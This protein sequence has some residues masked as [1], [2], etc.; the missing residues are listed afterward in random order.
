MKTRPSIIALALMI[1][2]LGLGAGPAFLENNLWDKGM[3]EI[4]VYNASEIR[5]GT[6]RT[7][8]VRHIL[9]KEPWN[10]ALGVKSNGAGD[11]PVL[12]LNQITSVP[13]GSYR[14][15]QMHSL[16]VERATGRT[17]KFS[18]SHHDA[19][20]NTFKMGRFADG[21]LSLTW[22]TY[23]DGEGDGTRNLEWKEKAHLYEELPLLVRMWA[24]DKPA[25]PYG[26]RLLNPQMNSRLGTPGT[27]AARAEVTTVSGQFHFTINHPGGKDQL[28]VDETFP[29]TLRTWNRADGSKLTIRKTLMLDYWNKNQPG[30]EKL[31]E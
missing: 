25:F 8:E 28:V 23:W 3:A 11:R 26:L 18:Y 4:T 16:F 9:V 19:C 5:Y 21:L 27:A 17:V 14:Y 31:L 13:T 12:K 29:H 22:H 20:G 10:D 2:P 7:A 6:A 15:E 1:L 30:D 24:A